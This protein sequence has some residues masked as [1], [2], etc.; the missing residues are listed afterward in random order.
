MGFLTPTISNVEMASVKNMLKQVNDST[1]LVN[2][3][4]NPEVFFSRLN[5]LFDL[6][7][8]LKKYEKYRIFTGKTPTQ[9]YE[10]LQKS[11][12][13]QVNLFID[14]TYEKQM[15]KM[16]TLKTDK[17]KASSFEKYSDKMMTAFKNA[18]SYWQGNSGMAHYR[19]ALYTTDNMIHL[20]RKLSSYSSNS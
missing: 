16:K 15:E 18:N 12:E 2:T 6:F 4:T 13:K 9:D 20:K 3:T 7:M 11:L 14:R 19:G 10:Y 1:K 8:E 17:S 5:M